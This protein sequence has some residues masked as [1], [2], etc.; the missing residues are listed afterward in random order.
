MKEGREGVNI[1]DSP[2]TGSLMPPRSRMSEAR[3][4]RTVP[5]GPRA[6]AADAPEQGRRIIERGY[7]NDPNSG[8]W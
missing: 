1:R 6:P 7:I 4:R 2:L 8:C 5:D 3:G